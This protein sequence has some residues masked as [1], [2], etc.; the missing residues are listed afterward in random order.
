M[1][2]R[3]RGAAKL[4]YAALIVIAGALFAVVL[5]PFSSVPA[6]VGQAVCR[7][8]A[9]PGSDGCAEQPQT[10]AALGLDPAPPVIDPVDAA[11]RGGYVAI[12]DSYSSGVGAGDYDPGS[13]DCRRSANAYSQLVAEG[14]DFQGGYSFGACSGRTAAQL[15]DQLGSPGAELDLVGEDTSLVSLNIGGNDAG[16][17]DVLTDCMV[18][19]FVDGS[20]C[21]SQGA[22]IEE[23]LDRLEE[24][25]TA[26]IA[27]LRERAPQARIVIV[28]Y[29][30]LFQEDPDWPHW[31][32][33]P[34]QQRFLNEQARILN[35]RIGAAVAEIDAEI[36]AS[37]GPGS[38]EFIDAYDAYDGHEIG[39]DDPWMNG[40]S[41]D[42]GEDFG[43]ELLSPSFHPTAGGQ[44]AL[45]E[46]VREQIEAGPGRPIYLD[47]GRPAPE[48]LPV[49]G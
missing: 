29:P 46:L 4:E 12:G 20:S 1:D 17:A 34:S 49:G 3:D 35:D 38:V 26:V 47:Q 28:G 22:E 42:F 21:E 7:L 31:S 36:H 16:F 23:R 19:S 10:A 45:S 8:F 2:G 9:E 18:P 14:H 32:L 39:T 41:V 6:E 48:P 15:L 13:G 5:A 37:Q 44:R 25:I 24:D 30:R 11:T 40:L 33:L 27:E 43:T